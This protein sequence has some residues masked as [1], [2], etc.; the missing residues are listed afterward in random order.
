MLKSSERKSRKRGVKALPRRLG[1]FVR[2][3]LICHGNLY[4]S[5]RRLRAARLSPA[6]QST[7]AVI[8]LSTNRDINA[9]G[10]FRNNPIQ[11][12]HFHGTNF[13]QRS[14]LLIPLN[15]CARMKQRAL[16]RSTLFSNIP[17]LYFLLST[18]NGWLKVTQISN[19]NWLRVT[20]SDFIQ[21]HFFSRFT[22]VISFGKYAT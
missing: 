16:N 15:P 5:P 21:K 9:L 1:S 10:L 11:P 4:K 17:D 6:S 8:K 19:Q 3:P 7:K 22:P 12:S 14:S 18:T 13:Q 2:P 20:E